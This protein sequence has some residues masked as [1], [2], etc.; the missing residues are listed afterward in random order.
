MRAVLKTGTKYAIEE[1]AW[2]L[3]IWEDVIHSVFDKNM[4]KSPN[5]NP[6]Y[7]TSFLTSRIWGNF[8]AIKIRKNRD[9]PKGNEKW[10]YS[11]LILS[12]IFFERVKYPAAQ[13]ADKKDSE[14]IFGS[15]IK[16][17]DNS[18]PETI[19]IAPTNAINTNSISEVL[20]YLF[21]S[22]IKSFEKITENNGHI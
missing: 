4:L 22:G 9:M 3:L 21:F 14:S 8:I 17:K 13:K 18:S 1:K 2:F 5:P 10:V 6:K 12:F 19:N 11:P 7:I 16:F 20:E 15:L